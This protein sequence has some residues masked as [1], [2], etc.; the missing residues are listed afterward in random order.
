LRRPLTL[1]ALGLF[2]L[3]LE[4][5]TGVVSLAAARLGTG[6]RAVLEGDEFL[7]PAPRYLAGL[8]LALAGVALH[9]GVH[10]ADVIKRRVAVGGEACPQCGATTRRVRRHSWHRVLA[11]V[12]DVRVTRRHCERCGWSGLAT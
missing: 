5:A 8:A 3:G 2:L 7:V 6:M 9:G 11:K 4:V 1:I 12:F 10:W